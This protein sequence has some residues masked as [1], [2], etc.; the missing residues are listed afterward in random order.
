MAAIP[1]TK[2]SKLKE[3]LAGYDKVAKAGEVISDEEVGE[4]RDVS[5]DTARRQKTFLCEIDVLEKDGHDYRLTGEGQKLGHYIRFNQDDQASESL[6]ILL[7]DYDPIP[8][9][10]SHFDSD[11]IG[12]DDLVDKVGFVTAN[13]LTS[14]RKKAGAEAIVELLEWTEFIRPDEEGTYYS[15]AERSKSNSEPIQAPNGGSTAVNQQTHAT[16]NQQEEPPTQQNNHSNSE[17][18]FT[19]IDVNIELT[20]S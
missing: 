2:S 11:G 19:S 8:K 18:Q 7:N 16:D 9:L 3:V 17:T 10:L 1:K 14:G 5:E 20:G 6:R 15:V 4:A 12:Y 13:E